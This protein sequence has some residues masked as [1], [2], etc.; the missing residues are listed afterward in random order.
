[1]DDLKTWAIRGTVGAVV[2]GICY[3]WRKRRK[4]IALSKYLNALPPDC[5]AVL[6][7]FVKARMHTV[8]LVPGIKPKAMAISSRKASTDFQRPPMS[9]FIFTPRDRM[10]NHTISS[11]INSKPMVNAYSKMRCFAVAPP[12]VTFGRVDAVKYELPSRMMM[13][14]TVCQMGASSFRSLAAGFSAMG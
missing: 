2:T 1:M 7:E 3:L 5:K 8:I 10:P 13:N 9:S 6:R 11:N 4:N 12:A 14:T